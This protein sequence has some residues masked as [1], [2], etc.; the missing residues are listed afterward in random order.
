MVSLNTVW[1][2]RIRHGGQAFLETKVMEHGDFRDK[3]I[4]ELKTRVFNSPS[5]RVLDVGCGT[6]WSYQRLLH[7]VDYVGMDFT[8]EYRQTFWF[9]N[10]RF[11]V[12]DAHHLP[13]KDN[14]FTIVFECVALQYCKNW[15]EVIAEMARVAQSTVIILTELN[16]GCTVHIPAEPKDRWAFDSRDII[17]AL[18]KWGRVMKWGRVKDPKG[19]KSLGMF[20]CE[21]N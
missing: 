21:L 3:L 2:K 19:R 20:V 1:S 15:R 4:K 16:N 11:F 5:C 6:A 9:P 13:F 7:A 14:S 8:P 10:H 17:N 12:A 18:S